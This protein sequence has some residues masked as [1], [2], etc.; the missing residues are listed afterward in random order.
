MDNQD[1]GIK[2]KGTE[3]QE[4][5]P[6]V[7]Q[8]QSVTDGALLTMAEKSSVEA[9]PACK[10]EIEGRLLMLLFTDTTPSGDTGERPESV[11]RRFAQYS[12]VALW[13]AMCGRIDLQRLHNDHKS[14]MLARV[15]LR[16]LQ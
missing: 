3:E 2:E 6:K 9:R 7:P 11:S 13:K 12:C 5:I 8:R 1:D 15:G 14:Y 16:V 10:N 4:G